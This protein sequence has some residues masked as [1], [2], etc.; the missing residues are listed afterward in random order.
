MHGF[1]FPGT[2]LTLGRFNSVPGVSEPRSPARYFSLQQCFQTTESD[3]QTQGRVK[4]V[5]KDSIKFI[6]QSNS[7]IKILPLETAIRNLLCITLPCMF[8]QLIKIQ[9]QF[10]ML[11]KLPVTAFQSSCKWISK[12]W[13]VLQCY[14]HLIS[15]VMIKMLKA[16]TED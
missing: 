1:I 12:T 4:D 5:F 14:L 9:R 6:G 2:S 7:W 16:G 11:F 3:T 13:K 10:Q 8:I 15:R